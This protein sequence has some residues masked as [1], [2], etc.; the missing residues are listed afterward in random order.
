MSYD[1]SSLGAAQQT[2]LEYQL[3]DENLN[4]FD[5][6]T[7]DMSLYFDKRSGYF[8]LKINK[9]IK[10][11]PPTSYMI[12]T[13]DETLSHTLPCFKMNVSS[14]QVLQYK[15]VLKYSYQFAS[16]WKEINITP[17]ILDII[18]SKLLKSDGFKYMRSNIIIDDKECNE[19]FSVCPSAHN[20]KLVLNRYNKIASNKNILSQYKQ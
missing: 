1:L 12:H 13:K 11:Y 4:V 20:I 3:N 10:R 8:S 5:L 18:M 9:C 17:S 2:S 7:D 14:K 6:L 16:N 15:I 19:T